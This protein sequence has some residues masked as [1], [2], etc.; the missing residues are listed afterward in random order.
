MKETSRG[1]IV[2]FAWVVVGSSCINRIISTILTQVMLIQDVN[3]WKGDL[4]K[5]I[6]LQL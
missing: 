5:Y 2:V 3:V 4:S 6:K 1:E